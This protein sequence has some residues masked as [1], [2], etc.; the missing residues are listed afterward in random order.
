MGVTMAD[1]IRV[2]ILGTGFIAQTR[3]IPILQG[4][5]DAEIT[6]AWSLSQA[7][8]Q[9]VADQ[10]GIP[11]VVERREQI[12]E[13]ADI[14]AVVVATPPVL[15]MPATVAALEAGKHV[16]C[17]ARMARNLK[18]ARQMLDA[19]QATDRVAALYACGFGLKGDRVMRRLIHDEN[20]IGDI[21]EVRAVSFYEAVPEIGQWT[22]DPETAGVN[23]MLLGILAE[24]LYRWIDPVTAVTAISSDDPASVPQSLGVVAELQGGG[25]A[26]FHLSCRVG[27]GPGNKIEIYGTRGELEY[28]M[29]SEKPGGMVTEEEIFGRTEG[30]TDISPIEIPLAE[31]RDRTMD[32]EFIKAIR[33][34]TPVEPDFAEGIRYMEFSEA[35]AQSLYEGRKIS[36]PP[37][38]KM[39][40]FGKLL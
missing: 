23:T 4:L 34:G 7:D 6:H 37:E 28:R 16:L 5:P 14:D 21:L 17:Q 11:N 8:T 18:E 38:P 25:T 40:T 2:G 39:L 22:A 13:S 10:F 15:H 29:L 1:K 9:K 31:M 12:I 32:V 24:V 33:H 36:M 20:Y 27:H 35:V 26:S 19:S 3:H 30:E